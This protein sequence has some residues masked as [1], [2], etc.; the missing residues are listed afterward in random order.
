MTKF[1]AAVVGLCAKVH[2]H[3]RDHENPI[4]WSRFRLVVE[5]FCL[6]ASNGERDPQL[7]LWTLS[8]NGEV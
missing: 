5:I 2:L 1:A 4:M 6:T 7:R 8:T 3:F